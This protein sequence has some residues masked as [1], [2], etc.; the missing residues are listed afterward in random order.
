MLISSTSIIR[1]CLVLC[2]TA[3]IV[4]NLIGPPGVGKTTAARDFAAACGD[5]YG[6]HVT[7][8]STR[9]AADTEGIPFPDHDAQTARWYAPDDFPK[10]GPGLWLLDEF[11][12]ATEEVQNTMT[13]LILEGQ[14][15]SYSKPDGIFVV[16]AMNGTTDTYTTPLSEAM[17][18]RLC[19]LY[20]WHE[21]KSDWIDWA[22]G[23]GV[24]ANAIAF[25]RDFW[26]DVRGER[27]AF[28][29]LGAGNQN[30]TRCL[31]MI[32][33]LE[34]AADR[35]TAAGAPI[36]A[37]AALPYCVQG[38]IG[39]ART[40]KYLAHRQVAGEVPTLRDVIRDA[41]G[42]KVPAS[43][44]AQYAVAAILSAEVE[45]DNHLDARA[46]YLARLFPEIAEFAF[47]A[48]A[49]QRPDVFATAGYQ[50]HQARNGN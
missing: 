41:S 27:P 10:A 6:F 26:E 36:N 42:A 19:H 14:C 9:D 49:T 1:D 46:T 15:G 37:E 45:R 21:N 35:L 30:L 8:L 4:P 7:Q 24:H 18:Q 2:K 22:T 39:F 5:G 44:S 48:L 43:T 23:A 47:R 38:M 16:T 34:Q 17:A 11:D 29:D 13:R 3:G 32:S 20:L 33:R 12:R 28:E 31:D 50:A 40:L 25:A